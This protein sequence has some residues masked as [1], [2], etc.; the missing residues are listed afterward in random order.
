MQRRSFCAAMAA[1]PVF[2][3]F[4]NA[5]RDLSMFTNYPVKLAEPVQPLFTK[6]VMEYGDVKIGDL[7]FSYKWEPYVSPCHGR[8]PERFITKYVDIHDGRNPR[9]YNTIPLTCETHDKD[10]FV[11]MVTREHKGLPT[12]FYDIWDGQH[13]NLWAVIGEHIPPKRDLYISEARGYSAPCIKR[14]YD[15]YPELDT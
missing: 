15:R 12:E 6:V 2:G 14:S 1:L 7:T 10:Y 3:L 9:F 5:P 8:I 11:S 13:N 4:K